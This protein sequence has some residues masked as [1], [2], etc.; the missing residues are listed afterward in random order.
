M[1]TTR[2]GILGAGTVGRGVIESLREQGK[3]LESR[4]DQKIEVVAVFDRSYL[5]KKDLLEGIEASD[6]P[7]VVLENP[8]VDLVV[9]LIGGI[10]PARE[11]VLSAIERNKSV[12]T[13]NKALL[14][15]HG[16]EIFTLAQK[17]GVEIGFEAAVA[18]ALP[19]IRTLR[20]GLVVNHIHS[21]SGILNGT[22]NFILTRMQVD[23]MDYDSALSLAQQKGFAEADPSFDVNG[24][25][26]AQKLALLCGLGWDTFIPEELVHVEGISSI[27]K[28]DMDLVEKMG[29]VIRLLAMGRKN[30]DGTHQIRVHPAIIDEDHVLA[31]VQNEKNAVLFDT[32]HSGPTLVM[33]LGAGS[34]P[35]AASVISDI[36][37]IGKKGESPEKWFSR[38]EPVS[39]ASDYSYRFYLRFQ[40]R[41]RPGVLAEISAILAKFQIS[42][43][44]VH[45]QE[46]PEPV[47]LVITTHTALE[48]SML[49][50][51]E[52]VDGLDVVLGKTAWFRMVDD[53]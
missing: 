19:V 15:R 5:R 32:S 53:I 8:N 26:A 23:G 11:L 4:S 33:G 50:A 22:C 41:D 18:G 35:T 17:R 51:L 10:D 49:G 16:E 42:I 21:L 45:Q 46:G 9:E 43:A 7:S 48:S 3:L 52:E 37:S 31:H 28:I 13:A 20:S 14:A 27:R 12:V 1:K 24:N 39:I 29:S 2:I 44:T 30:S 25:D 36:V 38:K 40:T 47:H 6:Q 34:L